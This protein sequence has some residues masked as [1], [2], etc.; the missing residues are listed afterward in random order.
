MLFFVLCV[1]PDLWRIVPGSAYV[2]NR[3]DLT[4]YPTAAS[5]MHLNAISTNLL[6]SY[7]A[8]ALQVNFAHVHA[9]MLWSIFSLHPHMWAMMARL[10]PSCQ[11]DV[12][13]LTKSPQG[14]AADHFCYTMAH[15]LTALHMLAH[16][17]GIL[18]NQ[19]TQ[20][21]VIC[22]MANLQDSSSPV[23]EY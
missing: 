8:R 15:I 17:A 22:I 23:L 5:S 3:S 10:A 14:H 12:C 13:K 4:M 21:Q 16:D 2:P 19:N 6:V 20:N 18:K 1:A 11:V 9:C 7:V